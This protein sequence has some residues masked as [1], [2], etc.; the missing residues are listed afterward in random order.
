MSDTVEISQFQIADFKNFTYL[1]TCGGDSF[2][3]DPQKDLKPWLEKMRDQ[4]AH[5]KGILLTHSHWDHV[6]GLPQVEEAFKDENY[7]IYVHKY[8][9][10]RLKNAPREIQDRFAFIE[11]GMKLDL[12]GAPVV[13][14]HAPGHSSGECNFFIAGKP[15]HLITGD[16][17]FIGDVGRTDLG[18]G[19]TRELFETLQRIKTLPPD[20][21]IYPGHDY[22]KTPTSTV[23][24]QMEHSAAFRCR[25]IEELDALP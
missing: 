22:G 4:R 17:V 7:K 16:T 18:D 1:I 14:M 20:T 10:K 8:E 23:R 3:V 5:L 15:S 12:G 24:E 19:S 21:I 13:V 11:E 9:A 6:I 2:V 25:T